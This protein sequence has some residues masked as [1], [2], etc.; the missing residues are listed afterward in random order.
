MIFNEF[1][2]GMFVLGILDNIG[3]F[4]TYL[5]GPPPWA[6]VFDMFEPSLWANLAT[7]LG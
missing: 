6:C 1:D 2:F 4:L 7:I 5:F 3:K